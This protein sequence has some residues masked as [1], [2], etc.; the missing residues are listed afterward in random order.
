MQIENKVEANNY[1]I[2]LFEKILPNGLFLESTSENIVGS[3]LLLYKLLQNTGEKIVFNPL[4][5]CNFIQT[6]Y[7]YLQ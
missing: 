7:N 3:V 6:N 4:L 5:I 1:I 2:N